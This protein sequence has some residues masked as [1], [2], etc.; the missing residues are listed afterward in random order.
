MLHHLKGFSLPV[1]LTFRI[2]DRIDW[3]REAASG[4]HYASQSGEMVFFGL[5][6][7]V[8][9]SQRWVISF[10]ESVVI[11]VTLIGC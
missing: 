1:N 7:P 10:L 5:A 9:L 6:C 3:A 11:T 8:S 2:S 4:I